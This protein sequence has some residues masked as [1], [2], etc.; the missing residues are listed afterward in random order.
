MAELNLILQYNIV[1]SLFGYIM[2]IYFLEI[3]SDV[4]IYTYSY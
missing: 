1:H 2:I 4:L 3:Q